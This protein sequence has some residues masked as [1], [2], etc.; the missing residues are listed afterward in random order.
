MA[1]RVLGVDLGL[2]RTGLAVSDELAIGTTPLVAMTPK[3]RAEDIAYILQTAVTLEA[4]VI[5]IGYPV[6]PKSGDEGMMAKRARGFSEAL[7]QEITLQ[8]KD[9]TVHLVDERYSSKEAQ[10]RLHSRGLKKKDHKKSLDS[11]AARILV[12]E[13]LKYV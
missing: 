12:E 13:Y 5:V 4:S 10:S 6:M 7:R 9:I 1:A 8:G 11:E 3:S 2:K